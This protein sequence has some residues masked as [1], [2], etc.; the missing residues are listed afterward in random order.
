MKISLHDTIDDV[1]N[2]L[3]NLKNNM[4]SILMHI[5][6]YKLQH[7]GLWNPGIVPFSQVKGYWFAYFLRLFYSKSFENLQLF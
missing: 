4:P 2:I 5:K 7:I 3:K 1:I 6:D